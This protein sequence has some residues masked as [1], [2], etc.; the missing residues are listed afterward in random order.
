MLLFIAFHDN[1]TRK[2]KF[3]EVD[4]NRTRVYFCLNLILELVSGA[5]T[6]ICLIIPKCLGSAIISIFDWH[7]K[8]ITC[9]L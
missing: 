5:N 2:D 8:L 3:S 7:D 6:E 4:R 9:C 1:G